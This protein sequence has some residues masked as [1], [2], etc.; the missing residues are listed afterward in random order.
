[1]RTADHGPFFLKEGETR[2][3]SVKQV[4]DK[5]HGVTLEQI[6]NHL[7]AHYGWEELGKRI[8]IRC[9]NSEPSVNSSLKF[10]RK[11][12]WARKKVEGL[13]IATKRWK[14]GTEGG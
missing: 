10:L 3:M 2:L 1:V 6:V 12:P 5:L 14:K 7:V 8:K 13:Y 4:K 11:T 9:F